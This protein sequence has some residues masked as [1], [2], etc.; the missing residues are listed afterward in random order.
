MKY[1]AA[2]VVV[3]LLVGLCLVVFADLVYET[4]GPLRWLGARIG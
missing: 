2:F 1:V 4:T 3:A